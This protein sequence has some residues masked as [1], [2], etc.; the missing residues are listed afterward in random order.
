[1]FQLGHKQITAAAFVDSGEAGNL[2]DYYYA[3]QLGV[4]QPVTITTVDTW[5]LS[6]APSLTK[7]YPSLSPL[8]ITLKTNAFSSPDSPHHLSS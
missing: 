4:A 8:V 6:L 2:I 7:L 5:H 1:M 3:A